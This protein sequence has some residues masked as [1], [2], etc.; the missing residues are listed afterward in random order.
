GPTRLPLRPGPGRSF[1]GCTFRAILPTLTVVG[2][3]LPDAAIP[4]ADGQA[5]PV[6]CPWC[7]FW[8][9]RGAAC[10]V[11]GSPLLAPK[12]LSITQLPDPGR[13]LEEQHSITVPEQPPLPTPPPPPTSTPPPPPANP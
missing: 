13:S 8:S 11:C 4:D 2:N 1:G 9:P 3:K 6:S 5:A 12:L 7:G 10:D